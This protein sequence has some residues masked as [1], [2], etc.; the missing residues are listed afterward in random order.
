MMATL[1]GTDYTITKEEV[2]GE[3]WYSRYS[4]CLIG[5]EPIEKL[6]EWLSNNCIANF[7]LVES[8]ESILAG[9]SSNNKSAFINGHQNIHINRLSR[10][11]D[12]SLVI[13]IGSKEDDMAFQLTWIDYSKE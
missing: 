12:S 3:F 2:V 13:K 1:N 11:L 9:G 8:R 4:I 7:I 6:I 5:D 10:A